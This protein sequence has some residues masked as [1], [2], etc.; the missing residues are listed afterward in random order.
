MHE[1]VYY[2]LLT[3]LTCATALY[4]PEKSLQLSL[5]QLPPLTK[6]EKWYHLIFKA[7]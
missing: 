3:K 4:L 6:E 2:T 7:L 5:P 1:R